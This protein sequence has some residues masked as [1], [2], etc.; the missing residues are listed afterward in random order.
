[1]DANSHVEETLT[2]VSF[3]MEFSL[4]SVSHRVSL[5]QSFPCCGRM[6]T[7]DGLSKGFLRVEA[8][9]CSQCLDRVRDYVTASLAAN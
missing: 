2:G 6:K 4:L 9:K 3:C 7:S 5:I 1:M 8:A